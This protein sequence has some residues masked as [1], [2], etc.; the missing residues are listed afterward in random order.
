MLLRFAQS[1]YPSILWLFEVCMVTTVARPQSEDSSQYISHFISLMHHMQPS[2]EIESDLNRF[3]GF[4][5]D[6]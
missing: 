3:A 6:V 2:L 4:G 5:T 1:T